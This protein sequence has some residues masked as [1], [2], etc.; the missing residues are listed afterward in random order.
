MS[1]Q[2]NDVEHQHQREAVILGSFFVVST[3]GEFQTPDCNQFER[4]VFQ[5]TDGEGTEGTLGGGTCFREAPFPP[6]C[7]IGMPGSSTTFDE[8]RSM[9]T[10]QAVVQYQSDD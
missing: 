6:L 10:T 5:R 7:P 4:A 1:P 8:D 3:D 2:L 9:S